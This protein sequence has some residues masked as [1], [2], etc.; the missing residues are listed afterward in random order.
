[1]RP[2]QRFVRT[3]AQRSRSGTSDEW[4]VAS[5]TSTGTGGER[6]KAAPDDTD[7]RDGLDRDGAP[8][9]THLRGA[10]RRSDANGASGTPI[11][12]EVGSSEV[13]SQEG[14]TEW[15]YGRG[16]ECPEPNA[17]PWSHLT[18]MP[19]GT[20]WRMRS[21]ASRSEPAQ[22][23]QGHASVRTIEG[24][25]MIQRAKAVVRADFGLVA[26]PSDRP[27]ELNPAPAPQEGRLG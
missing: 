13:V 3:V 11:S 16:T 19:V 6:A 7:R 26:A 14:E 1:M 9:W 12:P 4:T 10:L 21:T 22:S 2:I 25:E 5:R 17:P 23:E 27:A 8:T 20:I 18:M 15:G 24:S